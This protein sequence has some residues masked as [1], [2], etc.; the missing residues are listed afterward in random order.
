MSLKLRLLNLANC[1]CHSQLTFEN[2]P[3]NKA[4]IGFNL[5]KKLCT[6][7]TLEQ[8]KNLEVLS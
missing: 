4:F 3:S 1:V 5:T 6:I 7:L 2:Y 8:C